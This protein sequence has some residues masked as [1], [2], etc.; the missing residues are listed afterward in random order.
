VINI[1]SILGLDYYT[2]EIDQ[3]MKNFDKTHPNLSASQR[4]EKV[5]FARIYQLRDDPSAFESQDDFWDNF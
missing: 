4:K 2:S 5:K 3:F 1:R